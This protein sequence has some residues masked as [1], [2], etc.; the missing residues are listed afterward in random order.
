MPTTEVPDIP[1]VRQDLQ[2]TWSQRNTLIREMRRLRFMENEPTV[3]LGLEREI[4]RTPIAY[5]L[6]ERIIGTLTADPITIKVPPAE[7]TESAQRS[8]STVEKWL[9]AALDR[10]QQQADDDVIER[11]VESLIVDGHGCMRMLYAPQM[12][13]GHPK[14][15]KGESHEEY[16]KRSDAWEKGQPL[17]IAWSWVDPLNVYP[18]WGEA[19]LEAILETDTRNILALNP[20]R[21]NMV[22]DRPAL[23]DLVRMEATRS[24]LSQEVEFTQLWTRDS[25]TYAVGDT[26]IHHENHKYR[27]VPYIYSMGVT[28][29]SRDPSYMGLSMLYPL[30]HML[31]YLDRLLTQKASAIRLWAWPT[32]VVRTVESSPLGADGLP[33]TIELEPGKAITLWPGEDISFLSWNGSAPDMD[34]MVGLMMNMSEKAGLADAMYGMNPGGDSG[35]A[36]NQLIAA[37]RMK[38]KPLVAH[39]ER[40]I[41]QTVGTLL[42][43]VEYQLGQPVYVYRRGRD[44]GWVRLAPDDLQGYR[45]VEVQLNPIMP[46]DSYA[47]SS[48]AI[49]ETRAG[50]RSIYSAMENIGIEQPEDEMQQ[51]LVEKYLASPQVQQVLI[52][53]AVK[54]FGLKM[55]RD[56]DVS[57]DELVRLMP[58]LPPALQAAIQQAI[59][60]GAQGGGMGQMAQMAQ[61]AQMGQMPRNPAGPNVPGLP[62]SAVLAGPNTQAAPGAPI[63]RAATV[64]HVGP[65]VQPSGI[66][67]GRAPGPRPRGMEG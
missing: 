54:R 64:G 5:Q 11:F 32:A 29:S 15:A 8:A 40:A 45:Q 61:M 17:P 37:A 59:M 58:Q 25:L 49:N 10:L 6:C 57:L 28:V 13:K 56:R 60:G 44:S 53:E 34:E 48:Q 26:I 55:Q 12:W 35:Y 50:L 51:I 41:E 21:F 30:R 39:A 63:P 62:N 3:P 65:V 7:K 66:A 14:R 43:I 9:Y 47:R 19:G 24:G 67:G 16:I 31:P 2:S 22:K 4:I 33:R 42:D 52:P 23:W 46:T 18:I 36:I 1:A 38:F 27:A 20:R